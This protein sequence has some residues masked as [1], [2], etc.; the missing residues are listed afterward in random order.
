MGSFG[1]TFGRELTQVTWLELKPSQEMPVD[2]SLFSL[3]L[4]VVQKSGIHQLRLLVEIDHYLG[5]VLY[6]PSGTGF[7]NH[8]QYVL[9]IDKT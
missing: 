6:I 1:A 2:S 8:Q 7:P 4:L 5:R 3:I 9:T